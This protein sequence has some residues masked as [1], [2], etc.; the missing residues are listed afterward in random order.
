ME[1]TKRYVSPLASWPHTRLIPKEAAFR[2][3]GLYTPPLLAMVLPVF[4]GTIWFFLLAAIYPPEGSSEWAYLYA[5]IT[6]AFV[7]G[8]MVPVIQ[9]LTGSW[10]NVKFTPDAVRVCFQD[11]ARSVGITF[12]REEHEEA[13]KEAQRE[14]DTGRRQPQIFRN[15]VQ[16]V[17]RYGEQRVVIASFPNTEIAKADALV[18]RL[19]F[20][21][22]NIDE[23]LRSALIEE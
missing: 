6:P 19:Q 2:V 23:M 13:I 10:V 1:Q 16:V 17:M 21:H 8:A 3:W 15:A 11:Y 12:R 14:L 7:A 5:Y 18:L 9:G 4:V 20:V 22:E